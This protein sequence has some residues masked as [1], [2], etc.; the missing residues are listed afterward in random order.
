MS[1]YLKP[2]RR[3]VLRTSAVSL[4]ALLLGLSFF[5]SGVAAAQYPER[6]L[7]LIVPFPPGGATDTVARAI[8]TGLQKQIHQSVVIENKS[9]ASGMI[10]TQ[11]AA[12][13]TPDGYTIMVAVSD[14][15]SIAPHV[16][17]DIIKY[18]PNTDFS[19]IGQI[20]FVPYALVVNATTK[21][22]NVLEFIEEIKSGDGDMTFS[23]YGMGSS[24]H[25]ATEMLLAETGG[26]MRHI[27]YQGAAPALQAVL[28][29]QVDAVMLPVVVA[30]PQHRAGKVK[31][32]GLAS[33]QRFPG[34]P[35]VS[36]LAEQGISLTIGSFLGLMAPTGTPA[37]VI[38]SLNQ[39]LNATLE[40]PAIQEILISSGV[41]PAPGSPEDF[42]D[43]LAAEYERWGASL[44][45]VES[46]DK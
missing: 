7:K 15:H 36:T 2:F 14:T 5:G 16:F 42:A 18:D 44:E 4:I 13:A 19:A 43:F 11:Y 27:P 35:S 3:Q 20:G 39:A 41:S 26:K 24:S 23:S 33:E 12:N 29:G 22:N 40:D 37:P 10:G 21:A 30:D 17:P 25:L 1:P 32:L 45:N 38:S 6:P 9:G 34:T 8:A 31:I 46:M 28:S